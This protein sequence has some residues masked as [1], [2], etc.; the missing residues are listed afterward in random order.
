METPL[1]SDETAL[2]ASQG[3]GLKKRKVSTIE[4]I[5]AFAAAGVAAAVLK[6]Y[7]RGEGGEIV[8]TID[9]HTSADKYMHAQ[10][11]KRKEEDPIPGVEQRFP[12]PMLHKIKRVINE[13]DAKMEYD[14]L[15]YDRAKVDAAMEEMKTAFLYPYSSSESVATVRGGYDYPQAGVTDIALDQF[16]SIP[17]PEGTILVTSRGVSTALCEPFEERFI[18]RLPSVNAKFPKSVLADGSLIVVSGIAGIDEKFA[19]GNPVPTQVGLHIFSSRGNLH[20]PISTAEV[21]GWSDNITSIGVTEDSASYGVH[22]YARDTVSTIVVKNNALQGSYE[23]TQFVTD[24]KEIRKLF[25]NREIT[26][27]RII[28]HATSSDGHSFFWEVVVNNNGRV[29]YEIVEQS[30]DKDGKQTFELFREKYKE[31]S[32]ISYTLLGKVG[33]TTAVLQSVDSQILGVV[34]IDAD[35][36]KYRKPVTVNSYAET[37]Q[38][39]ITKDPIAT[40]NQLSLGVID[41]YGQGTG[42]EILKAIKIEEDEPLYVKVFENKKV[43]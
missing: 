39:T 6:D 28:P 18:R 9:G 37:R 31:R 14:G 20:I 35:G 3:Q 22:D 4:T 11:S 27:T 26:D 38:I 29:G 30:I 2:P 43:K 24:F 10:A 23:H 36:N 42:I 7:L 33:G 32:G 5:A 21:Y 40:K 34:F 19:D 25:K 13:V 8:A 12:G 17:G 1:P 16:L 41:A 15:K